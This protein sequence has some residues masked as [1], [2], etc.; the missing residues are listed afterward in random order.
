MDAPL[1]TRL[2]DNEALYE[3]LFASLPDG[4]VVVDID[5]R[6]LQAN[7]QIESLFGYARSELL[8]NPVEI[9]VPERFRS[10]HTEQRHAYGAQPSMRSMGAG[11]ELFGRRK[12][13]SEFPVDIMLLPVEIA[14]ERVVLGVVRDITERKRLEQGIRQLASSDPLTGLGNYRR[15]REAFETEAKWFQRA[16][17][18]CALLLLDLDGLKKINDTHGHLAGSRALCRLA[19]VIRAECRSIDTP[20]RHGGDEFAVILPDTS[21]EGANNLASRLA[22]RLAND[23][24]E[25]P[26]SFSYG[27][28]VY[29]R[30]GETLDQLL[31]AADVELYAMKRAKR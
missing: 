31:A 20:A 7:P 27:V 19:D 1:K 22:E 9:L 21:A 14:E 28:G 18:A 4:I 23:G 3:K 24:G 12:D 16:G 11:L 10:V 30:D 5:G 2:L 6:I 29:A 8:G 17:R 13:G 25:I 26:V 15:L